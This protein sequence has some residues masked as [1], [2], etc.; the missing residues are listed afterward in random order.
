MIGKGA[1]MIRNT[2][3]PEQIINKLREVTVEEQKDNLI[4]IVLN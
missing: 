4:I 3:M 1:Y 2:H